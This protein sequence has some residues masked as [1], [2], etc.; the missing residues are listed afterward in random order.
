[1]RQYLY[2]LEVDH[3]EPEPIELCI[4]YAVDDEDAERK[5]RKRVP[6]H[7]SATMTLKRCMGHFIIHS[8]ELPPYIDREE[9]D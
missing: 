6:D 8:T 5:A 2:T 1:M 7:T 9:A 3:G 4:I